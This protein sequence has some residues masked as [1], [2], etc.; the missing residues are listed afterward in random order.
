MP[1]VVD[2][3]S[4]LDDVTEGRDPKIGPE[5]AVIGSGNVAMDAAR[6]ARRLGC[7]VTLLYRRREVDMPADE[8]E[9]REAKLEGVTFV[10]QAIP[11]RV[12]QTRGGLD[13]VWG[14]AKMVEQG[15]GKRP[16]PVLQEDKIHTDRFDTVIAVIGQGGG[17]EFIPGTLCLQRLQQKVFDKAY[18]LSIFLSGH[19]GVRHDQRSPAKKFRSPVILFMG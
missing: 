13:F 16:K 17:Y 15:P 10:T 4:V 12:V 18:H 1:G 8:E 19:K 3:L 2:G 5:V 14:E 9:I 7:D 11:V 6:T